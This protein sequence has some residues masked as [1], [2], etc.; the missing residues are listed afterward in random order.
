[1]KEK[2]KVLLLKLRRSIRKILAH[3]PSRLPMGMT[4]FDKLSNSIIDIYQPP[5]SDDDVKWVV[6]TEIMN[7][8]R[9]TAYVPKALFKDYLYRGAANQVAS[10][11]MQDIKERQKK[12]QEKAVE[13]TTQQEGQNNGTAQTKGS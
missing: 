10:Y 5:C 9:G 1:M 7:L 4:E 12:R 13:A 8:K 3:I 2:I 11:A 6:A